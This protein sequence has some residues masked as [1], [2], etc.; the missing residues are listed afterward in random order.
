MSHEPGPKPGC[1][2]RHAWKQLTRRQFVSGVLVGAAAGCASR[3]GMMPRDGSAGALDTSSGT[4]PTAGPDA[5]VAVKKTAADRVILGNTGIEVSRLAM[6]SGTHGFNGGSDQTRL[7]ISGFA[8]VLTHGYSQG[9]TFLET[10]DQYGAHPHM[11]EAIRLIGR[12]NV[13][14]LTKTTSE[15]AAGA[16]ADL[17]RFRRELGIDTID[18]LLLHNKTSRT[19]TTECAGAMDVLSRAKESGAIRAHGVSCHSIEALRLAAETPW[20]EVDLARINPAGLVMD[21]D[22]ATV[23]GVLRQMKAAGKGVIGMK[24]LGE[25]QLGGDLDTAIPHAVKLD[26]IDA[27][28][29]GFTSN[30]QL[31]QVTQRIAAV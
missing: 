16:Q 31:D 4:E 18:I 13:V 1:P 5:G 29:I 20:V 14:V 17:D 10:A 21:A 24:I 19:W 26:A 12:Q 15:T 30:T 7:G 22:P 6:G 28:T 8:A 3:T 23:I 25:G 9:L 11:K 27:F 2:G